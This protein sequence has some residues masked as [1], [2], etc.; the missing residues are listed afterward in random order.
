[1][2]GSHKNRFTRIGMVV[3]SFLIVF[4]TGIAIYQLTQL[5]NSVQ[6][7]SHPILTLS[8]SN[9]TVSE[10]V[11]TATIN[12]N[13][14]IAPTQTI[15]VSYSTANGTAVAVSDYI[16]TSGTITFAAGE[17]SPKPIN[18]TIVDDASSEST[19]SFL[20]QLSNPVI[21]A[22]GTPSV[23]SINITDNDTGATAT[24]QVFADALE[25]NNSFPE[26]SETIPDAANHCN[27]TFYPPGDQ[28]YFRWWGKAGITY[29]VTTSNLNP[30]LDTVL[31]VYD[32]NQS[33]IASN[34]DI[35]P[36]FFQSEVRFTANVDGFYYAR[37]TNKSPTDPIS[38]LYCFGVDST[39]SDTPTPPPGFPDEA[40]DCEFNSTIET[41]CLMIT[42]DTKSNLNFVPTV[43]STRD[44]DI[45]KMFIKPGIFYTCETTI[46]AG[47]AADTNM[48]FWDDNG[49]PFNPWLGND[50]KVPGGLDFGS[51]V[52]YLSTYTGWLFI[53]VG[54]VNEPPLVEAPLHE[55]DL[56]CT[57]VESTPT[58]TPSPTSAFTGG[59]GG[60]FAT[61]TPLPTVAF[62]TPL[63]TPTPFDV[64]LF[65]TPTPAPPPLVQFQPLPTAT[66]AGGGAQAATINVTLYYDSNNNFLPELTEGIVNAAV[67][68]YD[69][70]TGQ[71]ISFGHTN[72]TGVARF[73]AVNAT[74]AIRVVVPF[75]NYSQVVLGDS[76]EILVRV[77]PQPL[78]IGIP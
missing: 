40:D 65:F 63:P 16:A 58:P 57:A 51:E 75:L 25:P 39:V 47:S 66:P 9:L 30:A 46:P 59:G 23:S 78:P 52:S 13:V 31:D 72:E 43:G 26:A 38:K 37:V 1:M 11:G 10:G 62:P 32:S 42:G 20:L 60:G 54:P 27:L 44:T 61:V 64:S 24:P 45:Y 77:A 35:A 71:L 73:T 5:T 48:I 76:A 6:A 18:I 21:A 7:A 55:Y 50:D 34:D 14:S 74:S 33:L 36:G 28:D 17:T 22:L 69:N 70:G 41:A 19:Q 49:N 68:L 3:T 29:I 53:V 15:T 2:V 8:N 67:S 12:V 56:T 4:I